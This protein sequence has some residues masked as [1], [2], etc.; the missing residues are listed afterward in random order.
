MSSTAITESWTAC[1]I[2]S[3]GVGTALPSRMASNT[4]RTCGRS[5]TSVSGGRTQSS[6]SVRNSRIIASTVVIRSSPRSFARPTSVAC[7]SMIRSRPGNVFA[8]AETTIAG[9]ADMADPLSLRKVL[10]RSPTG[11]P[12]TAPTMLSSGA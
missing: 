4:S 5:R 6:M 2:S 3:G 9:S 12:S 11:E 1:T 7:S 10:P 8:R